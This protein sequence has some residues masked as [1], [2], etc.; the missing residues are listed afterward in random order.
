MKQTFEEFIDE[1]FDGQ[2]TEEQYVELANQFATK[3]YHKGFRDSIIALNEAIE[4]LTQ[5][6]DEQLTR[7][8]RQ[9]E[10]EQSIRSDI[11][12]GQVND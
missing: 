8:K 11:E 12:S 5:E 7:E 3:M 1:V 4:P 9:E 6:D 2:P 10:A